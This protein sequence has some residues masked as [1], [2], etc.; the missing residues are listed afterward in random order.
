MVNLRSS[1]KRAREEESKAERKVK[2]KVTPDDLGRE[3][4]HKGRHEEAV[5]FFLSSNSAD[6][7]FTLASMYAAGIKAATENPKVLEVAVELD[8][9]AALYEVAKLKMND[10][11]MDEYETLV[12]RAA[13]F[14]HADAAG[15]VGLIEEKRKN[16]EAAYALFEKSA[17][18]GS[19]IGM[20]GLSVA[21][22]EGKGCE[23]NYAESARLAD[24]AAALGDV[25]SMVNLGIAYEYGHGVGKNVP[26]ALHLYI[27][28]HEKGN[29]YGTYCLGTMYARGCGVPRDI[30]KALEL[31]RSAADRGCED[32]WCTLG[33]CYELG[34]GVPKADV[35]AFK[36]YKTASDLGSVEGHYR[37]G[38]MYLRGVH[39]KKDLREAAC[40]F[41][42]SSDFMS[43]LVTRS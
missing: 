39:V 26:V 8:V 21:L 37:L 27:T 18:M 4:H 13:S 32:A 43:T 14:G 2:P 28:A 10:K 5:E 12:R 7:R 40:L 17:S 19:T 29:H 1:S 24:K 11:K 6:A 42:L 35:E 15:A 34:T 31:Y 20:R 30:T 36:C 25:M 16:Y 23:R 38:M 22:A 3:A 41:D 9:P 33:S